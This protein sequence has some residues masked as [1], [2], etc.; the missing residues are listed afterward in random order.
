MTRDD[1]IKAL[2]EFP[3]NYEVEIVT[4]SHYENPKDRNENW[5]GAA[6]VTLWRPDK[7]GKI[8]IECVK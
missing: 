8:I 6:P 3:S 4:R 7:Q 1:L 2:I 5:Y